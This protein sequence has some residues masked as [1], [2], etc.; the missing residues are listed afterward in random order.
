[1][2]VADIAGQYAAAGTGADCFQMH[3]H[4]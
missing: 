4:R 3:K 1:M 2:A